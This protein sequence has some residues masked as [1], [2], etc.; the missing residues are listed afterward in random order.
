MGVW[1]Q[2]DD[3]SGVSGGAGHEVFIWVSRTWGVPARRQGMA[4]H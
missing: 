2:P 1:N 4:V 3:E